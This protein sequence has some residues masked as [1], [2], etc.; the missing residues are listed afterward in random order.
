MEGK[1]AVN[2]Q[3]GIS[4]EPYGYEFNEQLK[5]KIRRRD[6]NR[7]QI[8]KKRKYGKELSVHHIDYNKKNNK[9]SNFITLCISCHTKTTVN[10]QSWVLFFRDIME[11]RGLG[12]YSIEFI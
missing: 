11:K 9:E 10:R 2:W 3:G 1:N 7:C 6:N 5:Q 8:C 4:F 12:E